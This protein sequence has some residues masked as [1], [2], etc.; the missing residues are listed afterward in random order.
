MEL[1]K[2][3]VICSKNYVAGNNK[4]KYCSPACRMV[5]YRRKNHKYVSQQGETT[6]L[7]AAQ[8]SYKQLLQ[9]YNYAIETIVVKNAKIKSLEQAVQNEKQTIRLLMGKGE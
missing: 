6:K 8:E 9:V 2:T 5:G 3:C 4:A 1:R 7:V